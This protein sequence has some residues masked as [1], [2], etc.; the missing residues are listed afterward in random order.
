MSEKDNSHIENPN[1]PGNVD[2]YIAKYRSAVSMNPECGNSHYNL[3]VGYLGKGMHAEAEKE[4]HAAIDCSPSLAEAYVQLGG[5]ALARGDLE[6]CLDWN[7]RAVNS[8]AG[9][10]EGYGNL[11]F[12]YMQMGEAELAIKNLQKA[13]A[14]NS[15]FIQAYVTL[16]SAYYASGLVDESI[17]ASEKALSLDENFA[18]AHNNLAIAYLEKGDFAMA[19]KHCVEA[20]KH[21]YA[22]ADEIRA[23]IAAGLAGSQA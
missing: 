8:R 23:D 2:E 10:S 5:L 22:V 19:E 12:V 7:K 6:G 14:Y 4:L 15:R 16:A 18:V 1:I 9:F 21:G 13:I 17:A 11:G 3:A 20:G